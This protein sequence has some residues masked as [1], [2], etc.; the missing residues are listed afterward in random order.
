MPPWPSSN[1]A[2][3][4]SQMF[5]PGC[6]NSTPDTLTIGFHQLSYPIGCVQDV[7][8][9][10]PSHAAAGSL[11]NSMSGD[12][13]GAPDISETEGGKAVVLPAVSVLCH[14][15]RRTA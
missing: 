15:R 5:E 13:K 9:V 6:E 11:K 14:Q 4:A 2:F 10:A 1:H 3:R 8:A 12:M 7:V